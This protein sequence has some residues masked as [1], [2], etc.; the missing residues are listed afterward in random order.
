MRLTMTNGGTLGLIFW[1]VL[2]GVCAAAEPARPNVILIMADDLGWGDLGCYGQAK[3]L[4]PRLDQ[5]AKEGMR[6]SNWYAGSTVCAPSRCVLMT[7]LHT[8]HA[9]IRGNNKLNLRAGDV[10]IAEMFQDNGYATACIGKWGLGH[11]KSAG[12]PTM[13]GFD[14]FYGYLDQTH[15]HNYFPTFLMRGHE[16]DPVNNVVPEE[17]DVGQGVATVRNQWSHDLFLGETLDFLRKPPEKPFFLYLPFTL[18]HANN[19]MKPNG[20]E[21]PDLGEYQDK[22]WP[23]PC[24]GTAAMISRLDRDVGLILDALQQSDLDRQ[25]LVLFTSDNGP[26]AEG[27]ND[28]QFFSSSGPYRGIKRALY[29]GGIRV[30]MIAR[31]PGHV[32]AGKVSDHIGY[33]GDLF[34][35]LCD[36][37]KIAP[38]KAL[39]SLSVAPTLLTQPG[40]ETHDYLYWEFYEHGFVQAVRYDD[41]KGVRFGPP[42]EKPKPGTKPPVSKL[43]LY[44]LKDDPGETTNVAAKNPQIV[45]QLEALLQEAHVP[46]DDWAIPAGK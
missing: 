2:C 14:R 46:S 21:I 19:E 44:H 37:A 32:A 25:T 12:V 22:D 29:E 20:M 42:P 39:D 5:M 13:Q 30:P 45:A 41:W 17:G 16:R 18:P 6:F 31:W 36:V 27:G 26:H 15:A 24:K 35:T 43:E 4:T 40:Q 34:T 3:I 38:I 1:L 9:S 23:A 7:G 33:H 11:E 10:T 8:G 28:P